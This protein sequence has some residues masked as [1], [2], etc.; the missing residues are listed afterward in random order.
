[1][2]E[3]LNSKIIVT[4]NFL[5]KVVH[6]IQTTKICLHQ[7]VNLLIY[8]EKNNCQADCN[9]YTQLSI[10]PQEGSPLRKPN[11]IRNPMSILSLS[12]KDNCFLSALI[13]L[14]CESCPFFCYSL[15][16][17]KQLYYSLSRSNPLTAY[18]LKNK[19]LIP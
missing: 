11:E 7:K 14:Q 3:V 9:S 13:H 6:A 17:L 1:M 5:G 15:I 8:S 12:Q 18:W 2:F 16:F 19:A 4:L 10:L